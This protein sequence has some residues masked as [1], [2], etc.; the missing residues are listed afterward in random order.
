MSDVSGWVAPGFERV[1]DAFVAGQ[2][3][4][5]GGAQLCAYR[6][7][8]I[9]VDLWS[10]VDPV[11]QRPYRADTLTV[12]M[13]C[14][15][16]AVAMCVHLLAQRGFLD[17]EAPVA[18]YWPEFVANG[19]SEITVAHVLSHSAGLMGFDP[20]TPLTAEDMLD[21]KTCT[22]AL[23]AMAPLWPP[24]TAYMYHFIT[25]G[26]LLGEVIRRVSGN[27]VGA[28]VANEL[29]KPLGLDFWVGLPAEADARVAPHF[30]SNARMEEGALREL[31]AA[32]GVDTN[33]RFVRATIGAMVTTEGLIE[34]MT[35]RAGRAA[36]VPAGNGV[37]NAR[38]LAKLYAA[39]IGEVDGVQ[40]LAPK[41]LARACVPRTDTLTGPKPFD[42][43]RGSPQRF[44][45]G[46]ELPR[47]ICPML[48][49]GSFGHPGA[50]G[51]LAFAHPG[52]GVAA[53]YACN[54]LLWDGFTADPRWLW[55]DALREA[56]GA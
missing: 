55:N 38:A 22:D 10:G 9:V 44:G 34:L 31:F 29:A 28:F 26:Y 16:A 2:D 46:F 14:T 40:F 6:R 17:V 35:T 32:G 5:R 41:T 19:K 39:A 47:D 30:R 25:Y 53:A 49:E 37:G 21:W 13:S 54:N 8:E 36:E 48:G 7:G 1:R 45:L 56:V 3:R 52:L 11:N 50:G 18:R 20:E 4:D 12:L 51:R 43:A 27:T 42:V 15:K 23:A 33:D 24:G